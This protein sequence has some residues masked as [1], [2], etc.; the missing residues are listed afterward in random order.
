MNGLFT[1]RFAPA[2]ARIFALPDLR[3]F[4][5]VAPIN[6]FESFGTAAMIKIVS[7]EPSVIR[8]FSS[9]G[10]TFEWLQ[11]LLRYTPHRS[12]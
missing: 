2:A 3:A 4:A 11:T 6:T 9:A 10:C 12:I 5:G 1:S 7:S 8:P